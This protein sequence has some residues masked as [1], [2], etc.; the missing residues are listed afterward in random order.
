[1]TNPLPSIRYTDSLAG[2][3][4]AH[5]H[6]FFVGWPNPPTQVQHLDSLR[7][8]N[9]VWLARLEDIDPASSIQA[10]VVGCINALTDGVLSAFIPQL[11]VLP[12]YQ[13]RGIGSNLL[14][15]MLSTLDTLYAIDLICDPD[16]QP[17][18]AR[19]GGRPWSGMVWRRPD[20]ITSSNQ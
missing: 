15:R 16:V 10:P 14:Q 9:H 19:M 18:Y 6:G 17:F 1:M 13:H 2:I 20:R 11:E 4:P 12:A 7:Q 5:L 8:S 3:T